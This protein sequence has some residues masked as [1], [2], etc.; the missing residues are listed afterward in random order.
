[1]KF[2]A[3]YDRTTR[4]VSCV[5]GAVLLV[6]IA[7][8]HSILIGSLFAVVFLVSLAW[9][10]QSY[11]ISD[12]A[13]I[14]HRLIGDVRIALDGLREARRAV[15]S[16]FDGCIRLWG[17]GGLFGYYGLFRTSK[18]GRC[19]WYL[20]NRDNA[21]V[22]VTP[23]ITALFS[24]DDVA[25]FLQILPATHGANP[26]PHSPTRHSSAGLIAKFAGFVIAIAVLSFVPF[27][28]L[29]SPG[30]PNVTLTSSALTVHDR[31]YPV[32]VKAG[33]V[34]LAGVRVVDLNID[35]GWRPK[36][37]TNGFS[38]AHYHSGWYRVANGQK[39][40]IYWAD[41]KRFVLLPPK[42]PAEAP[43]LFEAIDPDAFVRQIR[44][45]WLNQAQ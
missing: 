19:W 16:D 22:L 45:Q 7:L 44:E 11:E 9:S 2:S 26:E 13:I 3:T 37:R 43:V 30:P 4:V 35:Q 25:G 41:G 18:L 6:P 12:Q 28:M 29:Y 21:V 8:T 40:R 34:D 10:P 5:A 1:M 36:G 15:S 20:T 32:T 38:N 42:D 14:V 39:A 17:N 31:F 23:A 33:T 27:V 24:P